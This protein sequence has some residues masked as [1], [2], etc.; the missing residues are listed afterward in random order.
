MKFKLGVMGGGAA[1]NDF[2]FSEF[3]PLK[4]AIAD[5]QG[6]QVHFLLRLETA[7]KFQ[8]EKNFPLELDRN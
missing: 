5:M 7:R 1:E 3:S 4:T 8:P 6:V 2:I